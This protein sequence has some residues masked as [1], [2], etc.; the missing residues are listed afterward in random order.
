MTDG[1]NDVLVDTSVDQ[2]RFGY[3]FYCE[4]RLTSLQQNMQ[5]ISMQYT[6]VTSDM[7][8]ALLIKQTFPQRLRS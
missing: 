2:V 7:N 8:M 5:R 4:Q 1:Q 6:Q 3:Q